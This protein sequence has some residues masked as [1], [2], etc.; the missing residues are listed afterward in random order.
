MEMLERLK[1]VAVLAGLPLGLALSA[2][3]GNVV[4]GPPP[5]AEA[6]VSVAPV[7]F[8]VDTST[9]PVSPVLQTEE[10]NA[11]V[12]QEIVVTGYASAPAE[13]DSSP[14]V[15]ASMT[16][17][18]PGCLAL[19]RDLL[20][21]FTRNAPFDFGDW[22]VL[23]GVGIFVVQ[24]TMHER[25]ERRGDIW[26]PDRSSAMRWGSRRVL[27]GRLAHPDLNSE[28]LSGLG[29]DPAALAGAV[30]FGP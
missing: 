17:V 8:A 10:G 12:F 6:V 20:R 18:R 14:T 9:V 11:L 19:S 3:L 28:P 25:W 29:P 2:G 30:H 16:R 26:F 22:V 4:L 24:D 5:P 1:Q 15:T 21:T 23:P 13:T 27:V 7:V